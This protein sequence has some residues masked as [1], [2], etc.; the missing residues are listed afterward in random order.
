LKRGACS[1][2]LATSQVI[3]PHLNAGVSL[4]LEAVDYG[5]DSRTQTR[6]HPRSR[7]AKALS[8]I[9]ESVGGVNRKNDRP[10]VRGVEGRQGRP[11]GVHL[12]P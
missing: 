4:L 10:P 2:D 11:K 1:L 8:A 5:S 3:S 7:V 12:D 6:L 9:Y